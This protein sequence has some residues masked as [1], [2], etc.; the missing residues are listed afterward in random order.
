MAKRKSDD[1]PTLFGGDDAPPD[2]RA[3]AYPRARPL[4]ERPPAPPAAGSGGN[5]RERLRPVV[6]ELAAEVMRP[7]LD[8]VERAA[9]MLTRAI[10]AGTLDGVATARAILETALEDAGRRPAAGGTEAA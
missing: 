7:T 10:E 4:P 6:A 8:R 1:G 9:A 2:P 5:D 3:T